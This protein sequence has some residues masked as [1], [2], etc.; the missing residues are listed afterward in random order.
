MAL[1][2]IFRI[3]QASWIFDFLMVF[4]KKVQHELPD[5]EIQLILSILWV[6]HLKIGPK[7][8]KIV[9]KYKKHELEKHEFEMSYD[10]NWFTNT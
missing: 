10:R 9:R 7:P 4:F 1:L 5:L 8:K 3:S 2:I 6:W